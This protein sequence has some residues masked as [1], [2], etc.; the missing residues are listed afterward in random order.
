MRPPRTLTGTLAGALTAPLFLLAACGGGDD[1][2]A[3]PPVS[4]SSTSSSTGT[5]QRETAEAFIR[6][7]AAEDTRIQKT[8]RTAQFRSMS[9]GC[10]GCM[11]LAN[12]VDRIYAHGGYV[13]TKG[14]RI[15][16][17][18]RAGNQLFDL[19]VFSTRTTYSETG[20]GPVH[21]LPSGPAQFQLTVSRSGSSWNV[22][23][24]VQVAS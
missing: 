1:S 23:S 13:H 21:H 17:V 11:K 2:V 7:W 8:G 4:P 12:L 5:P 9:R 24:L 6:R 14:W 16:K 18:T 10:K 20:S 19:Y 3:D 15:E 22:T